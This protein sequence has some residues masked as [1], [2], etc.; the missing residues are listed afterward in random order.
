M[1]IDVKWMDSFKRSNVFTAKSLKFEITG[2]L[3]NLVI[4]YLKLGPF[5]LNQPDPKQVMMAIEKFKNA[6]WCL[7]EI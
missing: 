7:G 4:T 6:L 2:M 1:I 3:Y 5:L